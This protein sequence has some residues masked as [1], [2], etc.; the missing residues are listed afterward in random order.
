MKELCG[1]SLPQLIIFDLDGTLVD[2]VPDLAA[3]V[4]S[5]LNSY[6]L[7]CVGE[8]RVRL[9]VG[10]GAQAL[11]ERALRFV[12]PKCS[13][14]MCVQVLDAFLASYANYLADKSCLY[15]GVDEALRYFKEQGVPM[16]IVTNKPIAFVGP[17]LEGLGIAPFFSSVLGGDSLLA[18]KP[19]PLPL[20]TLLAKYR[21]QPEK[22]LMV[23]DSVSDLLAARSA[24]CAIVLVS[25]GY[26]HGKSVYELGADKVISSLIELL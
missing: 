3:A 10:N 14:D 24:G 5:A 17:L 26:N 1:G 19:D 20:N 13:D 12:M 4:D 8:E 6:G 2:S 21:V 23:G 15:I 16:A 25:Y 18:K 9:W 11:V 7:P 22:A